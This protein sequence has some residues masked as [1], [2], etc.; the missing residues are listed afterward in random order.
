MPFLENVKHFI[1]G[2]CRA[3][4]PVSV[5]P[6]WR[7][8]PVTGMV[9]GFGFSAASSSGRKTSTLPVSADGQNINAERDAHPKM[10]LKP[11]LPKPQRLR[12]PQPALPGWY[13]PLRTCIRHILTRRCRDKIGVRLP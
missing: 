3:A 1:T 2:V 12:L 7:R 10:H 5:H 13:P 6:G 11:G 9:T 8:L 4:Q